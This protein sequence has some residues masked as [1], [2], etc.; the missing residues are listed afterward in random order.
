MKAER[1]DGEW[2]IAS[3][4]DATVTGTFQYET[5]GLPQLRLRRPLTPHSVAVDGTIVLGWSD[6]AKPVTVEVAFETARQFG[7][8]GA[9][10]VERQTLS[11]RWALIGAHVP[12]LQSRHF[13]RLAVGY[14]DLITWTGWHGSSDAWEDGMPVIRLRPREELRADPPWGVLRLRPTWALEGDGLTVRSLRLGAGFLCERD[15]GATV[16]DWLDVV[17]GPLRDF[18]TILMDRPAQVDSVEVDVGE[19]DFARLVY[20]PT[21]V[22]MPARDAH[23]AE[24]P[25]TAIS[26]KEEFPTV[27]SRWFSIAPELRPALARLLATIY[28]PSSQVENK[29]LDLTSAAEAY[30]RRTSPLPSSAVTQHEARLRRITDAIQ[31]G[32]DKKWLMWRLR[33]GYEPTFQDRLVGLAERASPVLSE[34]LS[35]S[36]AFAER[37]SDARNLLVH[38]DPGT[39]TPY[40]SGRDLLDMAEDVS[41]V[42]MVCVYQDLGFANVQVSS[43]LQRTRRWRFAAMRKREWTPT[44]AATPTKGT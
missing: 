6:D 43:M 28:R 23:R 44:P 42:L 17:V 37:V 36:M 30:H 33:Y 24:L 35:D 1:F 5:G 3:K 22:E 9:R 20:A 12:D 21:L 26:I 25:C 2:W 11:V 27:V 32:S 38:L 19:D 13:D 31:S 8:A 40:P 18:L 39:A 29:F 41:L 34:W 15:P 14:S 7:S 10:Q 4:P 16:E